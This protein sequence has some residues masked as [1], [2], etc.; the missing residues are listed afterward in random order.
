MDSQRRV[1]LLTD[2]VLAWVRGVEIARRW[3]LSVT[4]LCLQV[5]CMFGGD[6]P[7]KERVPMDHTWLPTSSTWVCLENPKRRVSGEIKIKS[8]VEKQG[9]PKQPHCNHENY[10][11]SPRPVPENDILGCIGIATLPRIPLSINTRHVSF[12]PN[13]AQCRTQRTDPR[14]RKLNSIIPSK[15]QYQ[16]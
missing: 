8:G 1:E 14:I 7:D 11:S 6:N 16:E 2:R 10:S 3:G 13:I 4:K 12:C 15:P 5:H 9:T